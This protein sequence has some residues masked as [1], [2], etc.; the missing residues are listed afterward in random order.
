MRNESFVLK[1]TCLKPLMQK[2]GL[3]IRRIFLKT[4]DFLNGKKFGNRLNH[5]VFNFLQIINP[6]FFISSKLFQSTQCGKCRISLTQFFYREIIQL[7]T[8]LQQAVFTKF[9]VSDSKIVMFLHCAAIQPK[10]IH[11]NFF[12]YD[13]NF[14][15]LTNQVC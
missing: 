2:N 15:L 4:Q 5:A 14:K 3:N 6:F 11:V 7:F 9:F 8:R 1:I 10:G 12:A 13:P